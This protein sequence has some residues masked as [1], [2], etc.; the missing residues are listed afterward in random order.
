LAKKTGTMSLQ[1]S[2]DF[3]RRKMVMMEL[4][5]PLVLIAHGVLPGTLREIYTFMT[6]TGFAK[7]IL[8]DE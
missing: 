1:C 8:L 7:S 6:E 5:K 2:L 3:H 4:V